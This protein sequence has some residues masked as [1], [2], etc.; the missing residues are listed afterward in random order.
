MKSSELGRFS[1]IASSLLITILAISSCARFTRRDNRVVNLN[2][3]VAYLC[4]NSEENQAEMLPPEDA[5][6][7]IG[8][9]QVKTDIN[10]EIISINGPDKVERKDFKNEFGPASLFEFPEAGMT[11]SKHLNREGKMLYTV[12]YTCDLKIL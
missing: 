10:A 12:G 6:L 9:N 11:I 1:Y 8:N 3:I 5:T 2:Q 4:L 7:L